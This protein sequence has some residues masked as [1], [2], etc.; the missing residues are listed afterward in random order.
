MY[1]ERDQKEGKITVATSAR[2]KL[3]GEMAVSRQRNES[4][5]GNGKK[6]EGK[7]FADADS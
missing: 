5:P 4:C 7:E 6:V 3:A 1:A 2:K